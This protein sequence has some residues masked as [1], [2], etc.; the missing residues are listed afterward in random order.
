MAPRGRIAL[1]PARGGSKSIP[2]KNVRDLGGRPLIHWAIDA[3]AH[4][5]TVDRIVVTTDDE[6]IADTARRAGA[7][8]P[9]LRPAELATDD[10]GMLGVVEHA[11]GWLAEHEHAEPELVLLVQPTEPFVRP[12][13]IRGAL[14]LLLERG[15][16]SAITVVPV[17]RNNHPFHVRLE[18]DGFLEFERPEEHYAHASR[19]DDPPRWAFGNL[20]WFRRDAFLETGRIE[21][22]KCVGYPIDEVSATDLNTL[23]DWRLAETLLASGRVNADADDPPR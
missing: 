8:V 16:D 7:D 11:L 13:Q 18:R 10:A 12:E 19:H 17:P 20:Y 6:E 23:D 21:T 3:A 9:F 15:A 22:G 4:S 5:G 1:V 14:D 2:R